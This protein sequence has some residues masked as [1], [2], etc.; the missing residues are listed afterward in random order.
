MSQLGQL[1]VFLCELVAAP[2]ALSATHLT[3]TTTARES[4]CASKLG[5]TTKIQKLINDSFSDLVGIGMGHKRYFL[6][7]MSCK[8]EQRQSRSTSHRNTKS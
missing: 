7:P 1:L 6:R 8:R 4:R 2:T 3:L 5:P